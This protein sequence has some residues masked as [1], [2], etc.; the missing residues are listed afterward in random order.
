M[1]LDI[2]FQASPMFSASPVILSNGLVAMPT[3]SQ[4]LVYNQLPDGTLVQMQP[5]SQNKVPTI[6]TSQMPIL[7]N[8][9]P[10]NP[11][12]LIQTASSG[13]LLMSPSQPGLMQVSG[14]QQSHQPSQISPYQQGQTNY[15]TV[16][17]VQMMPGGLQQVSPSTMMTYNVSQQQQQQQQTQSSFPSTAKGSLTSKAKEKPIVTKTSPKQVKPVLPVD[18]EDSDEEPLYATND[19]ESDDD[20]DDDVVSN[21]VV[22]KAAESKKAT[23][24]RKTIIQSNKVDSS[25]LKA[26]PPHQTDE[27]EQKS[28]SPGMISTLQSRLR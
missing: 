14:I 12:Q 2:S 20:D 17:Q 15:V 27:T 13:T 6:M 9:Q 3:A 25:G 28:S 22:G 7:V 11:G 5:T 23:T 16:S 10:G 19:E 24:T 1:T 18:S 21:V 4:G 8:H 26:T